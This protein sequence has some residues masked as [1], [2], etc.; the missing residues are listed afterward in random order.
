[1]KEH[2]SWLPL[3]AEGVLASATASI[4][5][6][7]DGTQVADSPVAEV[8]HAW[9]ALDAAAGVAD[10]LAAVPSRARHA[11]V[12]AAHGALAARREEFA[13][14]LVLETGKPIVDC[15]A[16]VA[17]VLGA[18]AAT[19]PYSLKAPTSA[20]S[21]TEG[22]FEVVRPVGI[23]VA[24]ADFTAPLLAAARGAGAALAA[25][26]PVVCKPS[27]RTPLSTLALVRLLREAC[28]AAGMP[29]EAVQ[30]VPGGADI[31]Q[32]LVGDS[33]LGAVTFTG[34]AAVADDIARV[35]APR[36][37]LRG[38]DGNN[39]LV[40][41][42]DADLDAAA[43][44]AVRGGYRG[45]GQDR[46]SVQRLLIEAPAYSDFLDALL[47][48][49]EALA[50]G[51]PRD[52]ATH[53]APLIDARATERVRGWLADAIETGASVLTGGTVDGRAMRPT[54]LTEV[55]DGL[56]A[57]DQAALAP[58]VCVRAVAS[59]DDAVATINRSR[60]APRVSIFTAAPDN[61][62]PAI[63]RLRALSVSINAVAV[64][65]PPSPE[66]LAVTTPVEVRRASVNPSRM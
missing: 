34:S 28:G 13:Q 1:M 10:R 57:W 45:G 31:G 42:V 19:A 51:D 39:A 55:R 53:V 40:V 11:A 50:V 41:A 18:L 23:V 59:V 8:E 12:Q 58:L 44:A 32:A 62:W 33:R 46:D 60:H 29:V 25:G 4:P 38:V 15:R 9:A 26:C 65:P 22:S 61:T 7:Y 6:P 14:L 24:L 5:F 27:A 43:E 48:R 17:D 21:G 54:V 2:P 3:G 64:A 49:V 63:E 35:V 36:P 52:E 30:A 47:P 16:E 37:V 20:P 56:H 66:E